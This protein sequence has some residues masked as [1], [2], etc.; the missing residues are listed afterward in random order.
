MPTKTQWTLGTLAALA[1][2]RIGGCLATPRE[3]MAADVTKDNIVD[4]TATSLFGISNVYERDTNG[5]YRLSDEIKDRE[6]KE[7]IKKA[8]L[9]AKGYYTGR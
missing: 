2:L 5:F 8:I 1:L 6:Q 7:E 4:I 3:L 9:R